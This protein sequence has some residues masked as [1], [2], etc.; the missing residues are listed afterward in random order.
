MIDNS[1]LISLTGL[2]EEELRLPGKCGALFGVEVEPQA[3]GLV[4]LI[5]CVEDPHLAVGENR[6]EDA[7]V[8]RVILASDLLQ[9][10]LQCLQ[11]LTISIF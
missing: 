6:D 5:L 3:V 9:N 4:R 10:T 7:V 1:Y 11:K 8:V 2:D